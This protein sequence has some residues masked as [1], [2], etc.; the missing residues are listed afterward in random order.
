MCI[1]VIYTRD[2]DLLSSFSMHDIKATFVMAEMEEEARVVVRITFE[3]DKDCIAPNFFLVLPFIIEKSEIFVKTQNTLLNAKRLEEIGVCIMFK[4]EEFRLRNIQNRTIIL[5]DKNGNERTLNIPQDEDFRISNEKFFDYNLPEEPSISFSNIHIK[6]VKNLDPGMYSIKFYFY[7]T[8]FLEKMTGSWIFEQIRSLQI[9]VLANS[10]YGDQIVKI[11]EDKPGNE[12][13]KR[14]IKNIGKIDCD[15]IEVFVVTPSNV[16]VENPSPKN[17]EMKKFPAA[18][19]KQFLS[20]KDNYA[21]LKGRYQYKWIFRNKGNLISLRFWNSITVPLLMLFPA[22]LLNV[23][24]LLF[25]MAIWRV[26]PLITTLTAISILIFFDIF[27]LLS[28]KSPGVIQHIF[29]IFNEIG[30][31]SIMGQ[32]SGSALVFIL[33]TLFCLTASESDFWKPLSSLAWA[34]YGIL[35]FSFLFL[36]LEAIRQPNTIVKTKR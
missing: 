19:R 2:L 6:F 27:I 12:K 17:Y 33:M 28:I 25:L 15:Y 24:G 22:F 9:P 30:H 3:V 1:S 20:R 18:E 13:P 11:L 29:S 5:S 16:V 8:D 36:A 31:E 4:D 34:S 32:V 23:F 35:V 14:N 26:L 21:V 10:G 7:V